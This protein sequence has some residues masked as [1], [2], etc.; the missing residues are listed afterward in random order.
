MII[1]ICLQQ[2][3]EADEQT[4]PAPVPLAHVIPEL[5]N[6]LDQAPVGPTLSSANNPTPSKPAFRRRKNA[7]AQALAEAAHDPVVVCNSSK[8]PY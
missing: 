5:S 2:S 3:T 6:S 1:A 7:D 8:K 4:N